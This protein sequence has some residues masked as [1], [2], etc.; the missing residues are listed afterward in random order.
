MFDLLQHGVCNPIRI[1]VSLLGARV[2]GRRCKGLCAAA[3]A[4]EILCAKSCKRSAL[5][6]RT[7]HS[8]MGSIKRVRIDA[9][10]LN[11]SS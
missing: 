6:G 9:D 5:N 7:P 1:A 8:T 3:F 4:S 10:F 11:I 2:L